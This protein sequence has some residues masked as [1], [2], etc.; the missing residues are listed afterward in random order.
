MTYRDKIEHGVVA[1]VL[2]GIGILA[3]YPLAG[4][5]A[6]V[7]LFAGREHAAAVWNLRFYEGWMKQPRWKCELE[8]LKFWKWRPDNFFDFLVPAAVSVLGYVAC[9]EVC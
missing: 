3:G 2:L 6:G 5:V 8:A 9:M 7:A 1:A 4:A